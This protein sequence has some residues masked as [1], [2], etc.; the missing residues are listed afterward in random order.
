MNTDVCKMYSVEKRITLCQLLRLR[1][2][3]EDEAYLT[4]HAISCPRRARSSRQRR[5]YQGVEQILV[6]TYP[7]CI[8]AKSSVPIKLS[9]ESRGDDPGFEEANRAG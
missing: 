7:V 8:C 6:N 1:W 2:L 9:K 4:P 3:G 5:D